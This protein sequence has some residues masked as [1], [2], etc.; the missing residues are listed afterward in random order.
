MS[1]SISGVQ[2]GAENIGFGGSENQRTAGQQTASQRFAANN[3]I[4][5]S[6][7]P[8]GADMFNKGAAKQKKGRPSFWVRLA[9]EGHNPLN[10]FECDF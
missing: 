1:S 7:G 6:T 4:Y 8:S 5:N 10:Q 2:P 9:N 3:P